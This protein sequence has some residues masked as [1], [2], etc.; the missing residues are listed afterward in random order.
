MENKIE[1]KPNIENESQSQM[2]NTCLNQTENSIEEKNAEKNLISAEL[3]K[4]HVDNNDESVKLNLNSEVRPPKQMLTPITEEK[5]RPNDYS[6]DDMYL[7]PDKTKAS[8]RINEK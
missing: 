6:Q 1:P 3:I 7:S 4:T 8:N 2:H 5:Y